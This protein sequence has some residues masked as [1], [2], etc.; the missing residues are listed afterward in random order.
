VRVREVSVTKLFGIFDHRIPTNLED[1]ITIIHGPNGFGKTALL[2]LLDGTFNFHSAAL[3][4]IPFERFR[5]D[6]DNRSYL[7]VTKPN[8]ARRRG[9]K[10]RPGV[11]LLRFT[12]GKSQGE[13]VQVYEDK[14]E[15]EEIEA[16]FPL[17]M[18]DRIPNI[19]RIGPAEWLH[20]PDNEVLSLDDAL[21]R[22]A[23]YLPVPRRFVR[24]HPEV[25]WL[26]AVRS[27]VSVR[28]IQT[29][30]LV[31]R[32]EPRR[33]GRYEGEPSMVPAVRRYSQELAR[34]I[35]A[36]LAEYAA[37][38]Q[39]LDRSFP[40]R[41]VSQRSTTE[42]TLE[43][44]REKM[45]RLGEKR[46]RLTEAGLLAQ[47]RD[48]PFEIPGQIDETKVGVL[49]VYA[50]DVEEKLSVLDEMAAKIELLKKVINERFLYKQMAISRDEGFTFTTVDGHSLSAT[51]LS[52]GEQHEVVLLCELLFSVKPNLLVL[53]DEPEISLHIAWQE[54]FLKDLEQ[55]TKLSGFDVILATHSP[56]IVSDRWDLTVELRRPGE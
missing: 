47:E 45:D 16:D 24:S 5:V 17:S 1:R 34:A 2:R 27:D 30:R 36:K 50:S 6:F 18:L 48:I 52:S 21:E 7:E 23:E 41:L 42:S 12:Y 44:L 10:G 20:L 4:A 26:K 33:A 43:G 29:Q 40:A 13:D 14:Q 25:E 35:Q 19:E 56:Q 15:R 28:F 22:F 55:M 39:S 8:G 54:Q 32:G 3:R 37:V 9:R 49:S 46:A 11:P 31:S 38:S 51:S 53:I